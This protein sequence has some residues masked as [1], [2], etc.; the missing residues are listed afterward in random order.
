MRKF[1]VV[2]GTLALMLGLTPASTADNNSGGMG[3]PT[4][5]TKSGSYKLKKSLKASNAQP[6]ITIAADNVT[7]DLGGLT[8]TGLGNKQGTGILIEGQTNVAV[9]NGF[10]QD[11]GT[12]VQVAESSNVRI[13]GLQITG[14]D[15]PGLPPETGILLVNTRAARVTGN[16]IHR[17]FLGLFVRGGLSS[18]NTIKTNTITGGENGQLGICYN[19]APGADSSTDG[20]SG[21]LV[22]ENHVARFNTAIQLSPA[23]Q[24]NVFVRNYLT[25]FV[26]GFD[27]LTPGSNTIENNQEALLP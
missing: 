13:E 21:D 26:T 14:Q 8:L 23:T 24:S 12:A 15:V 22:A 19:P 20:P 4:V 25:Y 18:G 16:V 6:L 3:G 10:L 7:L 2:I 5:I 9:R 27:E 11:F 1:M 17:T